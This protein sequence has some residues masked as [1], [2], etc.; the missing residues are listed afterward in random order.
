VPGGRTE[1]GCNSSGRGVK[2]RRSWG[3]EVRA[4]H[5]AGR[6]PEGCR[7]RRAGRVSIP[8]QPS[9]CSPCIVATAPLDRAGTTAESGQRPRRSFLGDCRPVRWASSPDP[10]AGAG[11]GAFDESG[12]GGDRGLDGRRPRG[13]DRACER[14]RSGAAGDGEWWR[15]AR[16]F[17]CCAGARCG[18][19]VRC[20]V[21]PAGAGGA[22]PGGAAVAATAGAGACRVWPSGV[23]GRPG[24]RR[25]LACAAA[26]V[27][28]SWR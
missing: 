26:A 23:G 17:R 8:A 15:G 3:P 22:G 9:T 16:A 5:H 20:G 18:S 24:L 7:S 6:Q 10:D 27:P 11:Q 19:R 14:G 21:G 1:G 13:A 28:G 12:M 2:S 25:G 4:H